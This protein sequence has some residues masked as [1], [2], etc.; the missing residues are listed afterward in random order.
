VDI[1]NGGAGDNTINAAT[2]TLSA[3]DQING[4]VG[5]TN[6]LNLIGAGLFNLSL[7]TMLI[8][9]Q[10]V[11]AQEGQSLGGGFPAANQVIRL[12]SGLNVTV[13]VTADPSVNPSN[14]KAP[15]ITING[16]NDASV[17]NLASGNDIVTP[18]SA[19]ETVHG[20]TGNDTFQVTAATIGA[21]IDGG[22]GKSTL[23][24]IHGG[25]NVTMGVNITNI[26]AVLLAVA[27]SAM[28]FIANGISG[29]TVND[30]NTGADTVT[31]GGLN[32]TLT[33]GGGLETFNGF[34]GGSTTFTNTAEAMNGDTINNFLAAGDAI[35][36]TDLTFATLTYQFV[37]N[38]GHTA[39]TL[40]VGD[41]DAAHAAS[42]TLNG[43]FNVSLLHTGPDSGVG[44]R[45]TYGGVLT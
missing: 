21:T 38:A 12:R 29:L 39:A 25:T 40:T 18:G 24:E 41:G 20:G 9:V 37:E 31:A 15:T 16:A 3:G 14:P 2:N 17:I 30:S 35:D 33:G 5:G 42:M 10:V 45:F 36:L 34:A 7:P 11:N 32:Q 4:G 26:S 19:N 28:S 8:N 1:V 13:N 6:V 22:T 44:T 27:P 23:M 43:N